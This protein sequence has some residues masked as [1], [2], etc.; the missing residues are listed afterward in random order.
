LVLFDRALDIDPR[1]VDAKLA[2]GSALAGRVADAWSRSPQQ[3]LARAEH[4]L[5]EVPEVDGNKAR[6]REKMGQILHLQKRY[7]ESEIELETA[8]A[9]D[10]NSVNAL[11]WLA[12]TLT[13]LGEPKA[14]IPYL[15]KA[16]RLSPRDPNLATNYEA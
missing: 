15:E 5:L 13:W 14:A 7:P 11:G 12:R 6:A 4:L 1:S 9:R 2:L 16:L 8:I 10:R 3:E